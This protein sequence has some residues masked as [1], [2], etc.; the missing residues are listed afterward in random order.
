[1]IIFLLILCIFLFMSTTL[2]AV[3]LTST[4]IYF[5]V[6]S[7]DNKIINKQDLHNIINNCST[8]FTK[9]KKLVRQASHPKISRA[10]VHKRTYY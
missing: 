4:M 1:M 10:K 6:T 9:K 5:G 8:R 3:L 2:L 7:I